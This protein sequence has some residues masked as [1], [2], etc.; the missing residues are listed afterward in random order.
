MLALSGLGLFGLV[1]ITNLI[2][3]LVPSSGMGQRAAPSRR[4]DRFKVG[5]A[6]VVRDGKGAKTCSASLIFSS[7]L[8]V[9]VKFR[10][11]KGGKPADLPVQQVVKLE[12]VINL[13][14]AKAFGLTV[15]NQMQLLADEVIE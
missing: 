15:S 1:L 9:K 5:V 6:F 13:K 12:L 11:F 14:T 2:N 3:L 7:F 8:P 4:H 10:D